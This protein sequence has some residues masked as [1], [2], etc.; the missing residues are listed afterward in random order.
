M[1]ASE[2]FVSIQADFLLGFTN[3]YSGLYGQ[4]TA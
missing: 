4:F 2:W 3:V 1:W